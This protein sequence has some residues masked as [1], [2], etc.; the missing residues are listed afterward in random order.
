M[1]IV[2]GVVEAFAV[3]AA[4]VAAAVWF[5]HGS[6]RLPTAFRM[7]GIFCLW[8]VAA[9]AAFLTF[10]VLVGAAYVAAVAALD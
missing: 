7:V 4:S 5:W 6:T 1:N 8:A 3:L 2:L 9:Y 10:A